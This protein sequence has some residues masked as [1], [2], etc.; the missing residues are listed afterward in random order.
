MFVAH[1]PAGFLLSRY[2][3]REERNEAHYI[4][5]L[6]IGLIA[7]IAPDFDLAYFYLIDNRQHPHHSY[8]SHIPFFWIAIYAALFIPCYKVLG[9]KAITL[10]SMVLLCG[11]LH[12]VLDSI[13]SGI[14]WLYPLDTSYYGF[15]RIPSVHD[16]WVANYLFH[17][18]FLFELV[19]SIVAM[20]VFYRDRELRND[21][22]AQL[23]AWLYRIKP[24]QRIMLRLVEYYRVSRKE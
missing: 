4:K 1:M 23:L 12:M 6:I 2:L 17:W 10:I 5:F 11:L 8:W 3:L 24:D 18:T 9:K 14:K 13:A 7:S 15:W 21:L 22:K 19:I 20:V 16:W